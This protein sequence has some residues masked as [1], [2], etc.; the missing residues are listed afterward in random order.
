[1]ALTTPNWKRMKV[2][3]AFPPEVMDF[4]RQRLGVTLRRVENE[5]QGS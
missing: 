5:L 3:Y 1:V 4:I 2:S